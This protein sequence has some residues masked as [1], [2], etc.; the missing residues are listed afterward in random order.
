MHQQSHSLSTFEKK[1]HLRL[2]IHAFSIFWHNPRRNILRLYIGL[3]Y[4][5][6]C[7]MR[8]VEKRCYSY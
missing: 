1:E 3:R 6:P 7:L 4:F 8:L 2:L 5:G